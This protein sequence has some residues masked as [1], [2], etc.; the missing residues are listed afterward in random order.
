MHIFT[1]WRQSALTI[2]LIAAVERE[3]AIGAD[4]E[5]RLCSCSFIALE[6]FCAIVGGRD[7]ATTSVGICDATIAVA[8][9]CGRIC[10]IETILT[11]VELAHHARH[12]TTSCDLE[13]ALVS[14]ENSCRADSHKC[15]RGEEGFHSEG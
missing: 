15:G 5:S 1:T 4:G 3:S 9:C 14:S 13:A 6:L 8:I 10:A 12:A 7:D 11:V 2:E